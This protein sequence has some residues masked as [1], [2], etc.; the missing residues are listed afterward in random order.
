[1]ELIL[2]F[3]IVPA[4]TSAG[5]LG[6]LVGGGIVLLILVLGLFYEIFQGSLSWAN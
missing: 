3:P 1:V 2:V 5:S 6:V 4:I